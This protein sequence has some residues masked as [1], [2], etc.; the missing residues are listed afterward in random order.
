[1]PVPSEVNFKLIMSLKE[2]VSFVPDVPLISMPWSPNVIFAISVS[3]YDLLSEAC[4]A[5]LTTR[6]VVCASAVSVLP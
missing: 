5:G 6:L 4:D 3:K 1:M 2:I